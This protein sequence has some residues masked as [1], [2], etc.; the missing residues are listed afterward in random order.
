MATQEALLR[1]GRII[2]SYTCIAQ[3]DFKGAYVI[4]PLCY[5]DLY[6]YD[7]DLFFYTNVHDDFYTW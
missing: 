4:F 1:V 7:Y 3:V 5:D 6:V 2:G